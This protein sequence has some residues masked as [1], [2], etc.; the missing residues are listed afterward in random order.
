MSWN[1]LLAIGLLAVR[2]CTEVA[3][4]AVTWKAATAT[5]HGF[6]YIR[7][8]IV[9]LFVAFLTFASLACYTMIM[10]ASNR[11][12]DNK[13]N[14]KELDIF[15]MVYG[16]ILGFGVVVA[17]Y[18]YYVIWS[19]GVRISNGEIML[20]TVGLRTNQLHRPVSQPAALQQSLI[21]QQPQMQ[22][23]GY[24]SEWNQGYGGQQNYDAGHADPNLY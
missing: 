13:D 14:N 3:L 23:Q 15:L 18:C 21:H 6:Y 12:F 9:L 22:Q 11:E 20:V 8:C 7:S 16:S 24:N 17:I 1:L 2:G 19:Y 5:E 4:A 10:A